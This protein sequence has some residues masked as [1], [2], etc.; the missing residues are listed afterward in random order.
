M[1]L[2]RLMLGRRRDLDEVR[3]QL[4]TLETRLASL[5]RISSADRTRLQGEWADTLDRF[6]KL[7]RRLAA[8]AQRAEE[9][10]ATG[11]DLVAFRRG[12]MP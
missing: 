1:H 6:D 12:R 4:R 10:E 11:T 5:E 3:D 8:R 9:R 2:L 7:Y